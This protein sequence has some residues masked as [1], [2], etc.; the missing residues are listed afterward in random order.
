LQIDH[1]NGD[2]A[3]NR[4]ENLRLA[5]HQ[6]NLCNKRRGRNNSGLKGVYLRPNGKFTASVAF[7]QRSFYLGC[8][9]TAGE[10]HAAYAFA[11]ARLHGEFARAA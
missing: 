9:D 8:F 5:T 11:A 6:Q 1:V 10:A 2:P 3:D 7:N 4:L